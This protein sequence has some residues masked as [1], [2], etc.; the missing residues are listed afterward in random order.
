MLLPEIGARFSVAAIFYRF[1]E[2]GTKDVTQFREINSVLRSFRSGDAW[3][4]FAQIEIEIDAVIDLAF[5]WHT[6]H[7]LHAKIIL[8]RRTGF[9][10]T[11]SGA[12]IIHRLRVDR[13]IAHG[14]AVLRRHVS[15]GCAIRQ[16]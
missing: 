14:R 7:L 9:F 5:A 4:Y 2:Q 6:K 3:L 12:E 16:R 8:E 15:D 11:S 13:E 10:G 1:F